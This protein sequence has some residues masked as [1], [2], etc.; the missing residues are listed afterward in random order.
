M[1]A[2][3]TTE[4]PDGTAP[5]PAAARLLVIVPAYDEV[6]A[7]GAVVADLRATL[8]AADLLVIDDG[9]TDGTADEAHR[10]GAE[11]LRFPENRGLRAALPAGYRRAVEGGYDLCGR[12]DGDGQ[13]PAAELA[14]L[15]A[16]AQAGGADLVIGSRFLDDAEHRGARYALPVGRRVCTAMVRIALRAAIGRPIA[17]PLTGMS[18]AARPAFECLAEPYAGN[19]PEVEA[20]LRVSRA[21]LRLVEVPVDMRLRA[22]GES[23]MTGLA[24]VSVAPTVLVLLRALFRRRPRPAASGSAATVPRRTG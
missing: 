8:P 6:G 3:T 12:L 19:A 10:A 20:I 24:L 5:S 21:G 9:S 11:V 16:I 14:R 23:K 22:S 4:T 18:V 13:H 17:D 2:Q 15:V 1:L 7:I